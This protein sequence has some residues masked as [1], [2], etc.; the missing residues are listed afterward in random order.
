G[1]ISAMFVWP[2]RSVRRYH[3]ADA[4]G[5]SAASARQS[6]TEA[7]AAAV[8]PD[9]RNSRRVA[10]MTRE[11]KHKANRR[12]GSLLRTRGWNRVRLWCHVLDVRRHIGR[13]AATGP[14]EAADQHLLETLAVPHVFAMSHGV[15]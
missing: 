6:Q 13:D 12:G 14:R 3:G 9:L 5:A 2:Q 1:S 11:Q 4:V 7:A 15:E 10:G 8:M